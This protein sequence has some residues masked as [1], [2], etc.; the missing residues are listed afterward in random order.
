MSD[1][2]DNVDRFLNFN[3]FEVLQGKGKVSKKE[4]DVKALKEYTEYN[5]AQ[6]IES[7]FDRMIKSLGKGK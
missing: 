3:K 7:D 6:P 2:I 4:A 5:K 1:M